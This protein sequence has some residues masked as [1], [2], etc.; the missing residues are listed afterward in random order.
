MTHRRAPTFL[1]PSVPARPEPNSLQQSLNSAHEGSTYLQWDISGRSIGRRADRWNWWRDRGR[2]EERKTKREGRQR[3]R[4]AAQSWFTRVLVH[5]NVTL[6]RWWV[7]STLGRTRMWR[8]MAPAAT[9][10]RT[11]IRSVALT[12]MT[13]HNNRVFAE[14][15]VGSL[16]SV[17]VA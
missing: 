6:S 10:T 11:A 8:L 1:P 14:P 17:W 7:I 15:R 5:S 4:G 12:S 2:D 13:S 3:G 16:L 9:E